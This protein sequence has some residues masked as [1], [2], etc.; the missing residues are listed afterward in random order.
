MEGEAM[1]VMNR[2]VFLNGLRRR[3]G[4]VPVVTQV[5]QIIKEADLVVYQIYNDGRKDGRRI[6]IRVTSSDLCIREELEKKLVRRIRKIPK[7]TYAGFEI[8]S[9]HFSNAMRFLIVW[10]SEVK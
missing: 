2:K 3:S 10:T 7:V 8:C 9:G 5:R 6:K 1:S 4:E